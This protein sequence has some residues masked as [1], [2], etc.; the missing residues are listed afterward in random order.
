MAGEKLIETIDPLCSGAN[1]RGLGKIVI[2][3]INAG[4][5]EQY[6]DDFILKSQFD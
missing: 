3:E 2:K 1:L 6:K 4:F 5:N